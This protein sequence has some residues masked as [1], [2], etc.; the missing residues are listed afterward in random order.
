MDVR[1]YVRTYSTVYVQLGRPIAWLERIR[2][3]EKRNEKAYVASSRYEYERRALLVFIYYGS[4][5]SKKEVTA[6]G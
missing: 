1:T 5:G 2:K 4:T 6:N 3:L